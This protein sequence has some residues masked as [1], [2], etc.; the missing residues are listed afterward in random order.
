VISNPECWAGFTKSEKTSNVKAPNPFIFTPFPSSIF[1]LIYSAVALKM[2]WNYAL[3][4][5]GLYAEL[6]L[7]YD[8]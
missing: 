8:S 4:S 7:G 5:K 3:G 6:I 2:I 1:S